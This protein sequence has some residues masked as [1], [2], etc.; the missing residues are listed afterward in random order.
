MSAIGDLMPTFRV[1]PDKG[2]LSRKLATVGRRAMLGLFLLCTGCTSTAT[3]HYR[4][5]AL[6]QD[7]KIIRRA[8]GVWSQS[9]WRPII[10]FITPFNSSTHGQAIPIELPGRGYLFII[11]AGRYP[12]DDSAPWVLLRLSFNDK[13][14]FAEMDNLDFITAV[15]KLEGTVIRSKCDY[16][17]DRPSREQ[18]SSMGIS[19]EF[20]AERQCLRIG[21][22][23]NPKSQSD[24]KIVDFSDL[25]SLPGGS[26]RILGVTMTITDDPVT[27]GIEKILPWLT[28][29][30][31]EKDYLPKNSP[32]MDRYM[33]RR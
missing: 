30:T 1:R 32:P 7:G 11:P 29:V 24:F 17:K 6:I 15:S 31:S 20:V 22:T 27:T 2:P 4:I 18:I 3:V 19:P 23:K 13:P 25:Q 28:P 5:T 21:F 9:V 8:S 10:P 33:L 12:W 26:A 14:G 16:G